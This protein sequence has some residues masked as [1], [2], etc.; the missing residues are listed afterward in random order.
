MTMK[1]PFDRWLSCNPN[2]VD[3]LADFAIIASEECLRR[4]LICFGTT[5][6][7]FPAVVSGQQQL[8]GEKRL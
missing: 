6:E 3:R 8:F 4:Y 5:V 1:D 2:Q 7:C